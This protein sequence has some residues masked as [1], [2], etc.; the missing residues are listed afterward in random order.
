MAFVSDGGG[1]GSSIS[2]YSDSIPADIDIV[3]GQEYGLQVNLPFPFPEFLKGALEL[4]LRA[5]GVKLDYVAV[6]GNVVTIYFW[7]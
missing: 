7:G 3:P 6:A 5:A 2:F 4:A 1:G